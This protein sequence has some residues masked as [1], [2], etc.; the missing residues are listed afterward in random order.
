MDELA[1]LRAEPVN[2]LVLMVF[3]FAVL[4]VPALVDVV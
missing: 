3:A 1:A 2:V 4:V